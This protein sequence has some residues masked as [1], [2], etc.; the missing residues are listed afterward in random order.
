M[1]AAGRHLRAA[2][3]AG[4]LLRLEA[5]AL[6]LSETRLLA[7]A[8]CRAMSPERAA[9]GTADA[10]RDQASARYNRLMRISRSDWPPAPWPARSLLA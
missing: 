8:A 2:V 6:S 9:S 1:A 7:R 10:G 3:M 4:T 5:A